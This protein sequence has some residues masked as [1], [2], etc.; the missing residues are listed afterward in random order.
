[1]LRSSHFPSDTGAFA[2]IWAGYVSGKR[3]PGAARGKEPNSQCRRHKRCGFDP[4]V[5]K[6][7][8]R[9]VWQPTLV[10]LPGEHLY[11]QNY[12]F[13]SSHV[14]MW[15]L[16]YKESWAL[17]NW[18]FPTVVLKRLLRVPWTARRSS[19]SILKEINSEYS[20]EGPMLKLKF[21][22]FGHLIQRPNSLEKPLMLEKRGKRWKR[23]T[24]DEMV[25]C[26]HCPNGHEFEQTLGDSEGLEAWRATVHGI[27]KSQTRLSEWTTTFIIF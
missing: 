3:F 9:R 26:H 2:G 19:Q 5:G 21:Q 6:I 25:G 17:K 22:Y 11:G 15:E 23:V 7:P 12:G 27:T 20:L 1:M 24:E 4:W 18:C 10:F 16:D 8:W 14:W 13:S